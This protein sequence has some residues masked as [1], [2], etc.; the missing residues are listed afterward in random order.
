MVWRARGAEAKDTK[1]S[2]RKVAIKT[3]VDDGVPIGLLGYIDGDPIAWCSIAPRSTYRP[4]GGED[5]P[6]EKAGE[7]WSL[8]CFFVRREFRGQGVTEP[9]PIMRGAMGQ[10]SSRHIRSIPAR[11]VIGSWGMCRRSRPQGLRRL[12]VP[13]R[14]GT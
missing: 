1:G 13:A 8:V 10:R 5:E 7:E 2:G 6:S 9:P 14:V 3:L 11:R 4:L 12:A